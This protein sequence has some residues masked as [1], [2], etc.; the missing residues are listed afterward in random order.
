MSPAVADPV[1]VAITQTVVE[2]F[3]PERVVLF[4]SRARGDHRADSDYDLL[5]VKDT[6]LERGKRDRP[7]SDALRDAGQ[8]VDVI[9]YTPA[10]FDRS[11]HDEGAMAYASET[12]GLLL[13]DRT[14]SRWP[15]QVR[16]EPLGIPES[17]AAWL[18]RAESDMAAM[19]DIAAGSQSSEAICF[20][21]HQAAEKFHKAALIR[22]HVPPPRTHILLEVLSQCVADLRTGS[23]RSARVCG[24]RGALAKYEVSRQPGAH[25]RGGRDRNGRCPRR[26][27]L[28]DAPHIQDERVSLP[29][30][31]WA[32]RRQI[33]DYA[34]ARTNDRPRQGRMFAA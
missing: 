11:R 28:G 23:A 22:R 15:T 27:S 8:Y 24:A 16:E 17:L 3:A 32:H 25:A 21:A 30:V 18:A 19:V 12:E 26:A 34:A 20:H 14:P 5:V 7:I 29:S 31:H 33:R 4:G 10:E 6:A 2:R 9:V 13:Y 1:L